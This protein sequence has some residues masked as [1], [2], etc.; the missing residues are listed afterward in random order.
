MLLTIFADKKARFRKHEKNNTEKTV[1]KKQPIQC[2]PWMHLAHGGSICRVYPRLVRFSCAEHFT[3]LRI[4]A[5]FADLRR[6]FWV[7]LCCANVLPDWRRGRLKAFF[8]LKPRMHR[9]FRGDRRFQSIYHPG[10]SLKK[11][12]L[13]RS[14]SK[15]LAPAPWEWWVLPR[16]DL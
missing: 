1:R 10:S 5:F 3:H 6:G 8:Y 9:L 12:Q 7:V 15:A 16:W 11:L 4:G 13:A 2:N 14:P